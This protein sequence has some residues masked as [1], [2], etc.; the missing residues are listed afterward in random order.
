MI[1]GDILASNIS[2]EADHVT[3]SADEALSAS[4]NRG[5]NEGRTGQAQSRGQDIGEMAEPPA[6]VVLEA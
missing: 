3:A 5:A 2:W 4:E 6:E 1:G